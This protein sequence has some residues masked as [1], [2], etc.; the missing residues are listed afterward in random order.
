MS[1]SL[2]GTH[3][4]AESDTAVTDREA[5]E[6][7]CKCLLQRALAQHLIG[8][9]DSALSAHDAIG[10]QTYF[11]QLH[12]QQKNRGVSPGFVEATCR[13]AQDLRLGIVIAVISY[14]TIIIVLL[15]YLVVLNGF[16][17]LTS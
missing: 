14:S 7:R 6:L 17:W 5:H 8:D 13:S 9:H 1:L 10:P 15:K 16:I 11:G 3:S 2:L 12:A 4:E